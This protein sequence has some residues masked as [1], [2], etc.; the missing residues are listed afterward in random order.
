M[1][2]S[3]LSFFLQLVLFSIFIPGC[4]KEAKDIERPEKIVSMRQVYYDKETYAELAERWRAYYEEFP[5]EDSYANWMYAARYAEL[6]DYESLLKKGLDMYPANPTLL[7]LT[8]LLKHG[9]KDNLEAVHL[10]EKATKLDPTYLDPW[11]A[12]VVD[13]MGSGDLEKTDYAL[14]KLL[15]ER[16]ISDEVMD[17]NYNV[18]TLLDKNAIL[19]TNGD[20]DTYPGWII[21]RIV[22]YRPDVR[23][24]NR[25]LLN[26]EWYPMHLIKNEGIPNF[27]TQQDLKE[28]RENISTKLKE[29]KIQM[30]A[31]GPYSDTLI[32]YLISSAKVNNRPV[33]LAATLYFSETINAYKEKGL[34]LGLVTEVE[35]MTKDYPSQIRSLVDKWLNYF[36]TGGLESWQLKYAKESSAGKWLVSNYGGALKSI[37]N[38]IIKYVPEKRLDLFHWY[39]KYLIDLMPADKIDAINSSWCQSE[40]IKE[41][42]DWCKS[43]NYK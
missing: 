16:A 35:T 33:Y 9:T 18:I 10:L 28:L 39:Q 8:A 6:H 23:I 1:T 41:I 7:Y 11:F 26:T 13:Y 31:M 2:I 19:I 20:N 5:S 17:Y 32:T 29:G 4:T 36:R 27:I 40:D 25:S 21:T 37:M 3:Y 15:E 22:K 34:N 24:V 14:R 30:L 38:A 42:N 12:L 43:K